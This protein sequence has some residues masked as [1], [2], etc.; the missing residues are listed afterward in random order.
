MKNVGIVVLAIYLLS[1]CNVNNK[2]SKVEATL[3]GMIGKEIILPLDSFLCYQ[4]LKEKKNI[5]Q[6]LSEYKLVV[7]MDSNSCM[8]CRLK[9]MH[10]WDAYVE[11]SD[12][13]EGVFDILFIVSPKQNEFGLLKNKLLSENFKYPVFI[14]AKNIFS[15]FNSCIPSEELFHV[16]F[17]DKNNRIIL[18]G[19]PLKSN[20][21]HNLLIESISVSNKNWEF[22]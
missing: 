4:G 5:N 1:G 9:T 12:S 22:S 8:S 17:L 19:N 15:K 16:F 2:P 14:D 10:D 20:K 13:L 11:L 7:Y 3:E 18:V 6:H 21:I